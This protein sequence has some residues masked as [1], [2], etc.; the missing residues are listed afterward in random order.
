M[1]TA[2]KPWGQTA[3]HSRIRPARM[4]RLC[5]NCSEHPPERPRLLSCNPPRICL[6]STLSSPFKAGC[7]QVPGSET[8]SIGS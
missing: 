7:L 1:G 5:G 8:I 2:R 6:K 3:K 4:Y